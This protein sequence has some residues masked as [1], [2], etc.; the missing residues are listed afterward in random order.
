MV[1]HKNPVKNKMTWIRNPEKNW[2]L[3]RNHLETHIYLS[4]SKIHIW[5]RHYIKITAFM[6]DLQ[7]FLYS[8]LA[9]LTSCFLY[10]CGFLSVNFEQIQFIIIVP[11]RLLT[12][13]NFSTFLWLLKSNLS[14]IYGTLQILDLSLLIS[15][16]VIS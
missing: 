12:F 6:A 11:Y 15:N 10:W 3:E 5:G 13:N 4:N 8:L 1:K 16:F 7:E 2:I 9:F 14:H